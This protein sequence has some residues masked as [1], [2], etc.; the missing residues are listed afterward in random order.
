LCQ[1]SRLRIKHKE[2]DT[3]GNLVKLSKNKDGLKIDSESV[4]IYKLSRECFQAMCSSYEEALKK[5]MSLKW[6]TNMG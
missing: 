3:N 6:N 2:V 4:G 5:I 1:R